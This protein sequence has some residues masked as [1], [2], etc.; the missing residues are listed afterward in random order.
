MALALEPQADYLTRDPKSTMPLESGTLY[1]ADFDLS[2]VLIDIL[3]YFQDNESIRRNVIA[4]FKDQGYKVDEVHVIDLGEGKTRV[5]FK[6][7]SL[8][9][10][11][12]IALI[13]VALGAAIG[14]F[15]GLTS[16]FI[17]IGKVFALPSNIVTQA[18]KSP[19][20]VIAII[21]AIAIF[22]LG[23]KFK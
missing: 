1:F 20:A 3:M 14:I 16:L 19:W 11:L 21:I 6:P 23:F 5:F 10:A 13:I 18:V 2:G 9:V 4:Q 17:G 15:Y 12:A 22:F 7:H 8:T